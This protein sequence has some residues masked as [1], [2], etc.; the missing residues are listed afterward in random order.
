MLLIIVL[1]DYQLTIGADVV[2]LSRFTASSPTNID[3]A[4]EVLINHLAYLSVQI[5]GLITARLVG[6]FE[7]VQ[8]HMGPCTR[9]EIWVKLYGTCS[10]VGM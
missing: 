5:T 7:L 8:T 4:P 9:F 3:K 1:P 6:P 10:E 2:E